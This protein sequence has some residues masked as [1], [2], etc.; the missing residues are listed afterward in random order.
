MG[1]FM[2]I[3]LHKVCSDRFF[4]KKKKAMFHLPDQVLHPLLT[5]SRAEHSQGIAL[6]IYLN[7][8]CEMISKDTLTSN[9]ALY[10]SNTLHGEWRFLQNDSDA[11][12][13]KSDSCC[14]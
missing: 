5:M 9:P 1:N 2:F 6:S 14:E 4:Q 11:A 13:L 3:S 12:G 7:G 10:R 8:N